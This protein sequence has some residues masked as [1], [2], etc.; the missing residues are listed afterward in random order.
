METIWKILNLKRTPSN[1][2][3]I[4]VN[5]SITFK[6]ENEIDKRFGAVTLEGDAND[7]NFVPYSDLTEEMVIGWVKSMLGSESISALESKLQEE[8][9]SI[10]DKK[11][12]PEFIQENPWISLD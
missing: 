3:V 1:D 5:Y 2:L 10:I 6:L 9:Q 11:N 4:E 12:N 8:L 7:P